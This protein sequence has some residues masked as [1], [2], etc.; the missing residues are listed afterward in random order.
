MTIFPTTKDIVALYNE[1]TKDTGGHSG[2]IS[3]GN[4]DFV[5]DQMQIPRSIERQAAV[6]FFGVLTSH[7]FVDGNKRTAS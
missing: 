2:I 1:I 4:L 3:Y 7:P 5:I 6:L